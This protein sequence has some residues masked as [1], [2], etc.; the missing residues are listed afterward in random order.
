M[1]DLLKRLGDQLGFCV[2][3]VPSVHVRGRMVSSTEV[4]K[5]LST[6]QCLACLPA[7]GAALLRCRA[8]SYPGDGVGSKQ[9]VPTLNLDTHAEV[10]P[11]DGVYITRTTDLDDARRSGSRSP[12]SACGRPLTGSSARSRRSC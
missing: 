2:E 11:A 8:M 4:R 7:A 12:I 6:G 1:C 3:V 9:T 10:L 5:L